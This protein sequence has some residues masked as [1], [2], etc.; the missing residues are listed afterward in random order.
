MVSKVWFCFRQVLAR[1]RLLGAYK[2]H[3][4]IVFRTKQVI[5]NMLYIYKERTNM[6]HETISFSKCS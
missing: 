4:E 1:D 2:V 5:S 6:K 3:S